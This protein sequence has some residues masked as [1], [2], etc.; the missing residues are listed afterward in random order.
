MAEHSSPSSLRMIHATLRAMK[1]PVLLI[2]ANG[3]IQ[4]HNDAFQHQFMTAP[5]I[6]TIQELFPITDDFFP[7]QKE[8]V[9]STTHQLTITAIEATN[10][11]LVHVASLK[12]TDLFGSSL[13]ALLYSSLIQNFGSRH[14]TR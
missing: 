7:L 1:D 5:N 3:K 11:F 9:I 4:F 13:D 6:E 14:V 2:D 8:A 10:Y 12:I